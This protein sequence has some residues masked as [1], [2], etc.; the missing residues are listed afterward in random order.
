MFELAR[1]A[2][3]SIE[4]DPAFDLLLPPESINV[5]FEVRGRSSAEVCDRL[6]KDGRLLVGHGKALGRRA[7][8]MVC[9]NPD[10]DES[11]IDGAL[12]EIRQVAEELEPVAATATS[13]VV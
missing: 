2:A 11:D 10:L 12:S 9:V 4:E 3:A 13:E 1:Y 8:R 7:I 5:C 6:G